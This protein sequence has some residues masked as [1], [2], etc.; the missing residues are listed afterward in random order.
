[1]TE[2]AQ[3]PP[4]PLVAARTFVVNFAYGFAV[5]FGAGLGW[6]AAAILVGLLR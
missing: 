5:A 1:V 3:P 2:P 6:T 4:A